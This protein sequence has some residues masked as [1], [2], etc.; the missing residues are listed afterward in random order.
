MKKLM[1]TNAKVTDADLSKLA[2]ARANVVR[3]QLAA[4]IDPARLFVKPPNLD[5]GASKDGGQPTRALLTLQ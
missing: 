5:A 3:K 2:D 1:L 4:K